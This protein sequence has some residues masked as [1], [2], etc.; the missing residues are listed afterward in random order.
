MPKRL[1]LPLILLAVLCSSSLQAASEK[2]RFVRNLEAGKKQ[3]LVA[4]GTSLTAVG[5]WVDQLRAVADRQF[6]GL[7]TVVNGAQGGA[8]SDWGREKL[9]EKV[10]AHRPDTVLIEF[11]V[12][13]A[14][15]KPDKPVSPAKENLENMIDRI[16]QSNPDTEI[17]LMVMNPPVGHTA[18]AR[19]NLAAYNQMYR[20]VAKERRLQLIDHSPEWEK[21]L[22]ENPAL[23]VECVPDSIHPLRNGSLLVSAPLVIRSLGLA[24]GAPEASREEPMER[25]LFR[26]LMDKDKDGK[27]TRDEFQAFWT[28]QFEKTDTDA[29]GALDQGELHSAELLAFF[30]ADNDSQ[31]ALA[32]YLPKFQPVFDRYADDDGQTIN[33]EKF[34][35]KATREAKQ[36]PAL[37]PARPNEGWFQRHLNNLARAQQGDVDILLVGDSITE[38]AER[39]EPYKHHF[40]NRKVLNLGYGG[41]RTQNTLWHLQQGEADGLS[42]KIVSLMIGTNNAAKDAPEDI[43]LGIREIVAQLRQ[44]LPGAKII[45]Y[46]IFP[47]QDGEA[48]DTVKAVNRGLPALADGENVVHVDLTARFL[49]ENGELRPEYFH[50]DLL[51]LANEGYKIWWGDF[52][53]HMAKALEEDPRPPLEPAKAPADS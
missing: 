5:A 13:D 36:H 49:D 31:V 8:N 52:E 47:R 26:A 50:H 28:G 45:L 51:H 17:I 27:I 44:R 2:S 21:L 25:Y 10:L 35:G 30:D 1:L 53:S 41:D 19:P 33:A 43:L 46:S 32:E 24:P 4:F 12:N 6:P 48:Y 20:D 37:V 22:Q 23:F 38:Y 42:P 3:T 7:A 16:L 29:N 39:T 9:D 14:V 15:G 18:S 11:S 40:A 34:T